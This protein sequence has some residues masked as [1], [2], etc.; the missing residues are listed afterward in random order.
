MQK[1][2]NVSGEEEMSLIITKTKFF[3]DMMSPRK[4]CEKLL[5]HRQH[6]EQTFNR[7]CVA[8]EQ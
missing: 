4:S 1:Q 2:N 8:F 5:K 6:V 3:M 7:M